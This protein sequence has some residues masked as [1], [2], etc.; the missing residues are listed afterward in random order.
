L[1]QKFVEVMP[2]LRVL[3][4]Q[5]RLALSALISAQMNA[6]KGHELKFEQ[7]SLRYLT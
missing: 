5:Q 1:R 3:S 4:S 2:I 6:K 7:V